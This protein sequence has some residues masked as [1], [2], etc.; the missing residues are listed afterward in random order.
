MIHDRLRNNI[1]VAT[2]KLQSP[3][4][5]YLLHVSKEILI[6]SSSSN[7]CISIDKHSRSGSPEHLGRIIILT[8]VILYIIKYT[9]PAIGIAITVKKTARCPGILKHI[10]L[11]VGL[12]LR[13]SRTHIGMIKSPTVERFQPSFGCLN[14]AVQQQCV[15]V[16]RSLY[17]PIIATGKAI[18]FIQLNHLNIGKIPFKYLYRV[19]GRAIIG[20][21]YTGNI[22]WSIG[23]NRWQKLRQESLTIPVQNNDSYRLLCHIHRSFQ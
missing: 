5:V 10:A 18:V 6:E 4:K 20:H 11:P 19:I 17:R 16:A 23:H 8:I 13:H 2:G 12:Y 3:T 1:I 22:G 9:A 7:V 15:T 21:D 14:I